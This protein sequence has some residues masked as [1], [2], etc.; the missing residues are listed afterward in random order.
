VDTYAI[1]VNYDTAEDVH[2][3]LRNLVEVGSELKAVIIVNN[4]CQSQLDGIVGENNIAGVKFRYSIQGS[5][6]LDEE[7]TVWVVSL[8][9]NRGFGDGNNR[10]VEA[11]LS[12]GMVE[13]SDCVWFLNPDCKLLADPLG[14]LVTRAKV[15]K[16]NF[17]LGTTIYDFAGTIQCYGGG[18]ITPLLGLTMFCDDDNNAELDFISGASLFLKVSDYIALGGF[19]LDYFM[20]WEEV[21]LCKRALDMGLTLET[22]RES[23][24]WHRIGSQ[25]ATASLSAD[26]YSL[27]NYYLYHQKYSSW[28]RNVVR[29]P[30][31][32]VIK[33]LNRIFRGHFAKALNSLRAAFFCNGTGRE[34]F[35]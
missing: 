5:N 21:D 7:L 17:I 32:L 34:K 12:L 33:I 23:I 24:V 35:L 3:L 31:I 19:S 11:A 15:L 20:Y 29:F 27:R 26:F 25:G 22:V 6:D 13:E 9:Q 14:P 4:G 8:D 10:G 18:F 2:E 28:P 1:I 30:T 16:E